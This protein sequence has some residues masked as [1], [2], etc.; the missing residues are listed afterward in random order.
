MAS[1]IE[2]PSCRLND[3]VTE[4]NYPKCEILRGPTVL[5]ILASVVNGTKIAVCGVNID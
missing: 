5:T 3:T 2:Y 1:L 4:G